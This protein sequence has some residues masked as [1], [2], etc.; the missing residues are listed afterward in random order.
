MR[1]RK[2]GTIDRQRRESA[3]FSPRY[4]IDR[5]SAR[6]AD[7]QDSCSGVIARERRRQWRSASRFARDTN[8]R[9]APRAHVVRFFSDRFVDGS[10]QEGTP[11]PGFSRSVMM[12]KAKPRKTATVLPIDLDSQTSR[13]ARPYTITDS[14]VA[15]RAFEIY[16]ERGA[17][18]GHDLEHWLQAE[19]EL[20]G[21]LAAAVA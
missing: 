4:S 13:A 20:R 8:V 17:Q 15:R 21:S 9:S 14:D 18:H 12:A 16:C 6:V 19:S 1:F 3:G 5:F 7:R 11:P 10:V 2:S